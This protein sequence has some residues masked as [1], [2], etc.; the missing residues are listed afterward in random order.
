MTCHR[1]GAAR[2]AAYVDVREG[3]EQLLEGARSLRTEGLWGS[4]RAEHPARGG[5][6]GGEVTR[7]HQAVVADLDETLGQD[8]E[9][10]AAEELVRWNGEGRRSARAERDA[11]FV[12]G[13]EAMIGQ[14]HAMGV[15]AEIAENEAATA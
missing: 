7:G 8:M 4:D 1:A 11:A 6:L 5:K 10:E 2:A 12:E 13:D 9:H 14:A 3:E 15:A